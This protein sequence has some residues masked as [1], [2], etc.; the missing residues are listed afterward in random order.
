M[1]LN[2]AQYN[3][4]MKGLIKGNIPRIK[5][6]GSDVATTADVSEK[7]EMYFIDGAP[8]LE[9]EPFISWGPNFT[10]HAGDMAYDRLS[11][12]TY[13]FSL[14]GEEAQWILMEDRLQ[15]GVGTQVDPSTTT[16]N[17]PYIHV[18]PDGTLTANNVLLRGDIYA[19]NGYFSGEVQAETGSIGGWSVGTN[20]LESNKYSTVGYRSG[21]ASMGTNSTLNSV[22]FYAGC[23]N[24]S[25]PVTNPSVTN[26]YVTHG[27]KL[28]CKQ[29]T[30][31]GSSNDLKVTIDDT[32]QVERDNGSN[33][34]DRIKLGDT[35]LGFGL[36]F[37]STGITSGV[38]AYDEEGF[39]FSKPI[40]V[41]GGS[42]TINNS[43]A[44]YKAL[45]SNSV[46]KNLIYMTSG[47]NVSINGDGSGSTIVGSP[48]STTGAITSG[49]HVYVNGCTGWNS[50]TS[51]GFFDDSGQVCIVGSDSSH[52]PR[53]NFVVSKKTSSAGY[54][55]LRANNTSTTTNYTLTLPNST[56]TL[57]ISSSD[58]RLKENIKPTKVNALDLIEKIDLHEFD[59]KPEGREGSPHWKIGMIADELEK[60]DKNLV[61]GGGENEDG[62]MNVKGIDTLCLLSYLVGAVQEQAKE[63]EELKQK[64][65]EVGK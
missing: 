45:D 65:T 21:M 22:A 2:E 40:N 7:S 31:Y 27:G 39:E 47:N 16:S 26:F 55:Q 13:Q 62:S 32:L 53:V 12:N 37:S 24:A 36:L 63:I 28:Y 9:N 48:L 5:I 33:S 49:S 42:V 38:V 20:V 64:L 4:L 19:R 50:G 46:P 58:V 61:F 15:I 30:L 34:Y 1:N 43:T 8:T 6:D 14:D 23:A 35:G 51:G 11:G 17:T 44:A 57:A 59:W 54:T 18:S 10:E 25:G 41:Q 29:A 3:S 56:G 60:L 52:L